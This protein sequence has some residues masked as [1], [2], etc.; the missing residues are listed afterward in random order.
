[1]VPVYDGLAVLD[2][3]TVDDIDIF[4]DTVGA[5]ETLGVNVK[6]I[7]AVATVDAD[8]TDADPD[9]VRETVTLT[10]GLPDPVTPIDMVALT[11]LVLSEVSDGL[12]ETVGE[13]V[14]EWEDVI[15]PEAVGEKAADGEF[16][17]VAVLVV[18]TDAE[19]VY[20]ADTVNTGDIEYCEDFEPE[21]LDDGEE[22]EDVETV[23]RVVRETVPV[24]LDEELPVAHADDVE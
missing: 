22:I 5:G 15:V 2:T 4:D 16:V 12:V 6:N 23:K 20:A 1:M 21:G 7:D 9:D 3:D 18:H 14:V 13:A 19:A 8:A 24:T 17:D 11:E 10:L